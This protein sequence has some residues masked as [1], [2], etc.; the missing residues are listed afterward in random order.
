MGARA[1]QA[2]REDPAGGRQEAHALG[3]VD[4]QPEREGD[5]APQ[6]GAHGYDAGKKIAGRKRH[7]C[8][9]TLG[10]I[11]AVHVQGA[12]VQDRDGAEEV[13]CRMAGSFTRLEVIWADAGYAG[14]FVR[15]AKRGFGR[16]IEIVRKRVE[17]RFEAL[18]KRWVVER[19]FGWLSRYRR[20]SKDYESLPD[21]SE[22][23]IR[24][25]MINLML[26]RLQPG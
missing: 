25:A 2:P 1:R 6:R 15:W 24:V 21:S 5:G 17:G 22:A 13:L 7:L 12:G 3:G 23:M 9:D 19:T 14:G 4:R 18:P 26:H 8:V 11:L 16:V 20:L 10:L